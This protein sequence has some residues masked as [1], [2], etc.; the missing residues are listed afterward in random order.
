[1]GRGLL[2]VLTVTGGGPYTITVAD[3]TGIQAGDHFG[4]RKTSG[5][6]GPGGLW[7]VD[8]VLS[9]TQFTVT[10][11]LT[12]EEGGVYGAPVAS[13]DAWYSTPSV[14]GF[15]RPPHQAVAWDA[16]MRWNAYRALV[17]RKTET[18]NKVLAGPTTGSP[19]IPTFRSLVAAD[20]P[21]LSGT[22]AT[23]GH[24]HAYAPT[25]RNI[26]TTSPLT[27]GGDLS[28]DRT[29]AFSNQDANKVLAGPTSGA[30]AAPT[31]RSLVAAD[32]GALSLVYA[33][34]H[35]LL[36]HALGE[37][38]ASRTY[39]LPADYLLNE[40]S[41]LEIDV[42]GVG[43][44]N[45]V[46]L[47]WE[48]TDLLDGLAPTPGSGVSFS[49]RAL[50]VREGAN[51][52]VVFKLWETQA[53]GGVGEVWTGRA[54]LSALT[55]DADQDIVFASNAGGT[56]ALGG[57]GNVS[58]MVVRF[59]GTLTEAA[60]TQNGDLSSPP[61]PASANMP[62]V[63]IVKQRSGT[64]P[65]LYDYQAGTTIGSV[66]LT[67]TG[68]GLEAG[69]LALGTFSANSWVRF[70]GKEY[71]VHHES[72]STISIYERDLAGGTYT[73]V[74]TATGLS[75]NSYRKTGLHVT[76]TGT[77]PILW[78]VYN[79]GTVNSYMV[80]TTDGASFNSYTVV[81]SG[82]PA[83]GFGNYGIAQINGTA[84][85][86]VY[87]NT[88]ACVYV[89]PA[90]GTGGSVN[91]GTNVAGC[92]CAFLGRT[93]FMT[94]STSAASQRTLYEMVGGTF[95]SRLVLTSSGNDTS[96]TLKPGCLFPISDTEL[97]AIYASNTGAT[98]GNAFYR[99]SVITFASASDTAPTETTLGSYL[100][101][102]LS[103]A[104]GI[105]YGIYVFHDTETD[106]A[107]PR[108]YIFTAATIASTVSVAQHIAVGTPLSFSA[109]GADLTN[110][111]LPLGNDTM[112]GQRMTLTSQDVIEDAVSWA[113]SGTNGRM[114]LT[115]K[116]QVASGTYTAKV[117][118]RE[119]GYFVWGQATLA[120]TATGG[121]RAGN[122]VTGIA[123]NT[124]WTV[125]V[126]FG[127]MGIANGT[128]MEWQINYYRE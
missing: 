5:L 44:G 95:T 90:A 47:E 20:V 119:A 124:T 84:W 112:G 80:T 52:E 27:G 35:N 18:A 61:S 12:D 81:A 45:E 89:A 13:E 39:T 59:I 16:A 15:S 116:I 9:G 94:G 11:T 111:A 102:P 86:P 46:T 56:P 37:T 31:F 3:T 99:A 87:N 43:N 83:T 21:D 29:I 42:H 109:G 14:E 85:I 2:D 72:G 10:D 51:V 105:A 115:G 66:Q 121:T 50:L 75:S 91:F 32:L 41:G 110:Y 53:G 107:N 125:D 23:A 48:G 106:P 1:M 67:F 25:T 93:F 100:P 128:P 24:T 74:W 63:M 120:G 26:N 6:S 36:Y 113:T 60:L 34:G 79:T 78:F 8:T 98:A 19:A 49:A 54:T 71:T 64:N 127:S 38:G 122:T 70:K 88:I 82:G 33:L 68:E 77:G 108:T 101:S 104:G 114:T 7:A 92:F 65:E 126:D 118:M 17:A 69:T 57:N 96:T 76:N 103:A 58:D 123:D 55:L 73:Q 4:C 97:L 30:A 62:T 40:G 28:S 22:Y 117:F